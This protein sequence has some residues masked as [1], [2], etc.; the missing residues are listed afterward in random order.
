TYDVRIDIGTYG[1]A[2]YAGINLLPVSY[3][4]RSAMA[5]NAATTGLVLNEIGYAVSGTLQV[6]G[7]APTYGNPTYCASIGNANDVMAYVR[8]TD[9]SK[10][11]STSAPVTCGSNSSSSPPLSARTYDVRIDIGT[12]GT[13]SYAG[14]NLL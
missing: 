3:L 12:Y 4:A 6:G 10:G 5:V 8:F 7:A 14:I 1:T 11:Y 13:A 9:A 2:S